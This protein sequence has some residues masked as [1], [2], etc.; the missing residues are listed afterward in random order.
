M[1]DDTQ[2]HDRGEM[3]NAGE[4]S[5]QSER[6]TRTW[7]RAS[8]ELVQCVQLKTVPLTKPGIFQVRCYL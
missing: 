3:K 7:N 6:T 2:K 5:G 1:C 4:C 8:A